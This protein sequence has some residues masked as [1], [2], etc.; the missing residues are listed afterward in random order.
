CIPEW[1]TCVGKGGGQTSSELVV[2]VRRRSVDG[3]RRDL[4]AIYNFPKMKIGF[5]ALAGFHL[6]VDPLEL[7]LERLGECHVKQ[8]VFV[9][10]VE[11]SQDGEQRRQ[12]TVRA[13]VRLQRLDLCPHVSTQPFDAPVLASEI[14]SAVVVREG[15]VSGVGGI[16]GVPLSH[17]RREVE[18]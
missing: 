9:K 11:V 15:G 14:V 6:I 8:S 17:A 12:F 7:P 10:I 5:D 18:M 1:G 3:D 16:G 2:H 4:C 13:I